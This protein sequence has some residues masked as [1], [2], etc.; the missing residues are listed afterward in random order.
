MH[1]CNLLF[2]H[3]LSRSNKPQKYKSI[4]LSMAVKSFLD[5]NQLLHLLKHAGHR[6][7]GV[8]VRFLKC[9]IIEDLLI[10]LLSFFSLWK[11]PSDYSLLFQFCPLKRFLA[12]AFKST[13]RNELGE[14]E[15][16]KKQ[17][18]ATDDQSRKNK[19]TKRYT[20]T[21]WTVHPE[22]DRRNR[23]QSLDLD[24]LDLGLSF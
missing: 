24:V 18:K 17:E 7:S 6:H 4:I 15:G 23:L 21:F 10:Y 8:Q 2:C 5:Q 11:F 1:P 3:Y 13:V 16:W 14:R 12:F 19:E 22:T 20:R 9:V